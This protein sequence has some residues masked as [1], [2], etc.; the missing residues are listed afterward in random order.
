MATVPYIFA[1]TPGDQEIPLA[2][3]DANF[4]AIPDSYGSFVE[5]SVPFGLNDG[6]LGEDNTK[7]YWDNGVT[8]PAF[9][10]LSINTNSFFNSVVNIQQNATG[11]GMT[12]RAQSSGQSILQFDGGSGGSS[13]NNSDRLFLGVDNSSGSVFS[14]GNYARCLISGGN[15]PFAITVNGQQTMRMWSQATSP[16]TFNAVGINTAT[17]DFYNSVLNIKQYND[18]GGLTI[19][20]QAGGAAVMQFDSGS[21]GDTPTN[22]DRLFFGIDN[23]A[24]SGFSLGSYARCLISGGNYPLAIM[25]NNQQTMRM[26]SQATSPYTFNAVGINTATGDFYNSVLNIKQY[27]DGS[28]LTIRGQA[29]GAA[30][31]QFDSGSGGSSPTNSD[32]LFFGIDNST[33]SGFSSGNYAR[34]LISGGDYPLSI[35]VNNQQ[36]MRMWSQATSPYTFN[37]VG[38][39]TPTGDFYNSVLNIKQYADGGGITIRAYTSG[40]ST[41][42]FDGASGGS[43]PTNSDR[44]FFGIDNSTGSSFGAGNYSRCLWSG[45]AYNLVLFTNGTQRLTLTSGGNF[46]FGTSAAG[47][48]SV[49]VLAIANGTAPSTSPA[50]VGQLYVSGGALIYRGASGTVTTIA[51]AQ[52]RGKNGKQFDNCNA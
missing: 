6:S 5:G 3:L 30:I 15:Y 19:R 48:S 8:N 45:G 33:G 51:A 35:W 21:G 39:N 26:W 1:N 10:F 12:I 44:L 2:D 16:Y 37:A 23:S 20:G 38:I 28:G 24:G 49:N 18:G 46:G 17:G 25:V 27:A 50:G 40:A 31:M 43:S 22:L 4:A 36:T 47:T 32:R 9:P 52:K 34:C 7:L 13:P 29:N 41:I 42:Q 14:L 11:G